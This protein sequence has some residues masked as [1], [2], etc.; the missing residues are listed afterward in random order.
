MNFRTFN[1]LNSVIFSHLHTLPKDID[2]IAGIPRSGLL[3]ANIIALY[4]N[5]PLTD[6][7]SLAEGRISNIGYTQRV[8]NC[9]IKDISQA[10]KILV[11]DDSSGSGRSIRDA[12]DRLKGTEFYDRIIFCAVYVSKE[13]QKV[14]DLYFEL[15]EFPRMF[16]WN[17]LHHGALSSACCDIDG[18]LCP[19]PT[20]EQNDDGEKYVDFIRNV[21]ARFIPTCE[22]GCLITSRLEKYRSDTEYWLRKNNIRYRKL[23]MMNFATKQE[24][25][26]SG[27]HGK[28]KAKHYKDIKEAEI[29]IESNE[30]QAE[31][32]AGLSGKLVFC[33]DSHKVYP[34]SSL[35]RIKRK[36]KHKIRQIISIILPRKVKDVIKK[37]IRRKL[38]ILL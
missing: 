26:M 29:F 36:T 30:Y 4:L 37:V 6:I 13:A 14:P 7:G 28:F 18:V 33:T 22:I 31:E 32:I 5:L 2:I 16:E 19:D 10:R 38:Y 11:V 8:K 27:S 20:E 3:A 35:M 21:P 1:D 25:V 17:Y 34:E 24:R 23:I 12:K 15:V 9:W